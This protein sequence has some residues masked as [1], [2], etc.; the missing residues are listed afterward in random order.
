MKSDMQNLT[1]HLALRGRS[2]S[3]S[4]LPCEECL[5]LGLYSS[6]GQSSICQALC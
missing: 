3:I 4:S 1:L 6:K 5:I 2:V